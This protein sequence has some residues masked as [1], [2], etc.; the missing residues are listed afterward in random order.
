MNIQT[1]VFIF[2]YTL[3]NLTITQGHTHT[4]TYV[5][6]YNVCVCVCKTELMSVYFFIEV[7]QCRHNLISTQTLHFSF[8]FFF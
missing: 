6:I 1:C 7:L 4:D 8:F 3:I 5:F 2:T